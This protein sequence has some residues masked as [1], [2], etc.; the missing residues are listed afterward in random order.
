MGYPWPESIRR[1]D[2]L[3]ASHV[4]VLR[5][6]IQN[7]A[8]LAGL[9]PPL[10]WNWSNVQPGD[11][12][13]A[14]HFRDMR[15]AIER[16]WDSKRRGP[17]PRWTSGGDPGGASLGTAPTPITASDITD[18]RRWLD[19][20]IDNHPRIGM[21]T[22]SYDA[23]SINRPL[24]DTGQL[25]SWIPDIAA[26]MP[27]A[28]AKFM[29]RCAVST[30]RTYPQAPDDSPSNP[31][32]WSNIDRDHYRD[33]FSAIRSS[34]GSVV[35]VILTPRFVEHEADPSHIACDLDANFTNS[36]VTTFA[37]Q[38]SAFASRCLPAGVTNYIIW[39]EPNNA[40]GSSIEA[41]KFAA[42]VYNCYKA[43]KSVSSSIFVWW[44]GILLAP[45]TIDGNKV[46]TGEVTYVRGI[47]DALTTFSVPV[48]LNGAPIQASSGPWPWDGVN[49]HIHRERS[50]A[51]VDDVVNTIVKSEIN[52]HRSDNQST[53]VLIGECGITIE[54]YRANQRLTRDN[55]DQPKKIYDMLIEAFDQICHYSHHT[56]NEGA[57]VGVWGVQNW[58][59]SPPANQDYGNRNLAGRLQKASNTP[60]PNPIPNLNE[61][62]QHLQD[63]FGRLST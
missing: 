44:G 41:Q 32:G 34:T 39:N 3:K 49:F 36:F 17:V 59:E 38:A 58:S 11:R 10:T 52:V 21:D 24:V 50:Q 51:Y 8:N 57:Q 42:L 55:E 1:G 60:V 46:Q 62:R 13:E 6:E 29:V 16:L 4:S 53:P 31:I 7:Q 9:N 18:L 27:P 5:N 19:A 45:N 25:D 30:P 20:Y 26:F 47:Y 40:G 37:N 33:A 54:N 35:Y 12:V 48:L 22:K 2:P 23:G 15:R 63:S 43:L 56:Q 14:R 28:P 61:F